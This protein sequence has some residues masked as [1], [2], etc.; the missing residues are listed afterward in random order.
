[1]LGNFGAEILSV[2]AGSSSA[3]SV[4]EAVAA[5]SVVGMSRDCWSFSSYETGVVD[6]LGGD[7]V[8]VDLDGWNLS[9]SILADLEVVSQSLELVLGSVVELVVADEVLALWEEEESIVSVSLGGSSSVSRDNLSTVESG[10]CV[11]HGASLRISTSGT[12]SLEGRSWKLDCTVRIADGGGGNWVDRLDVVLLHEALWNRSPAVNLGVISVRS[13][14]G[15]DV[16]GSAVRRAGVSFLSGEEVDTETQ[17]QEDDGS[18]TEVVSNSERLVGVGEVFSGISEVEVANHGNCS[19]NEENEAP[20]SEHHERI[21]V[22]VLGHQTTAR[23][24]S[25]DWS[26]GFFPLSDNIFF[27]SSFS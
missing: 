10:D 13:V 8:D 17:T 7:L 22:G 26:A 5:L 4:G 20:E 24:E 14:V 19:G 2:L 27:S 1:L 23:I 6:V 18:N 21:D 11:S 9:N 3:G 12:S 25:S 15:S 16:V